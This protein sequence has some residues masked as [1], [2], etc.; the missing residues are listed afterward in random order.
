MY[1]KK[2]SAKKTVITCQAYYAIQKYFKG[3]EGKLDLARIVNSVVHKLIRNHL[4]GDWGDLCDEDKELNDIDVK[5]GGRILSKFNI[6]ESEFY[7]ITEAVNEGGVRPLTK[8][9]LTCEY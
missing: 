5:E 6:E 4:D 2:L 7:V 1:G 9:L 8:V 3:K